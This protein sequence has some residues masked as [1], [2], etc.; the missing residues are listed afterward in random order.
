LTDWR[1]KIIEKD[2]PAK[3]IPDWMKQAMEADAVGSLDA[4]PEIDY[5]EEAPALIRMEVRSPR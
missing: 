4:E 2:G 1:T 3:A 5:S